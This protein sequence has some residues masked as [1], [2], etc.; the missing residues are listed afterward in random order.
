MAINFCYLFQE[1]VAF[2]EDYERKG[3]KVYV[4]CRAGHGRSATVVLAWLMHKNQNVSPKQHN[5][6]LSAMRNV[7][8]KLWIQ[9]NIKKFHSWLKRKNDATDVST[10]DS[11]TRT[12]HTF[13]IDEVS[14]DDEAAPFTG[15]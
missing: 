13:E 11:I 8:K 9:P 3:Q 15:Q 10:T 6:R 14:S 2:I 12:K 5:K 4:H 7:R 1:A